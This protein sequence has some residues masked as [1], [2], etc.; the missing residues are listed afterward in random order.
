MA[1]KGLVVV[2][3]GSGFV[4][5]WVCKLLLDRGFQVRATTRTKSAEKTGWLEAMGIEVVDGCDLLKEGSFDQAMK[6]AEY[7]HHCASPFYMKV[8][9][10]SDGTYFT[11][12]AQKGTRNVLESAKKAG[13]IKRVVVTSSC[14]AVTWDNRDSHP[15]GSQHRWCEDDWQLDATIEKSAYRLSKRLAEEEAWKFKDTFSIATI[16]P[17]FILG[18]VLSSRADAQSVM[19]MKCLIDGSRPEI[20][21][22]SL[23]AV[24]VRDVA[25]AHVQ[26]QIRDDLGPPNSQGQHRFVLSN[27][28][29]QMMSYFAGLARGMDEFKN[30]EFP[31]KVED[32]PQANPVYYSNEKARQ[33]LGIKFR[34]YEEMVREGLSSLIQHEIV[35]KK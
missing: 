21:P 28:D 20:R 24:D 25:E 35:Q 31:E 12:P 14:A 1:S 9:P 23:G 17:A 34:S 32:E 29:G 13:T 16:C 5:S 4:A 33:Y 15:Q 3:G 30:Y 7:L 19:F 2:T 10:G 27:E 26:A 8:P 11:E 18:P 6:G 22:I